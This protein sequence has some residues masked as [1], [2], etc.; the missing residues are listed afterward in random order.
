MGGG[1]GVTD[2]QTPTLPLNDY[3]G[4]KLH[5]P[6]TMRFCGHVPNNEVPGLVPEEVEDD[7]GVPGGRLVRTRLL[8]ELRDPLREGTDLSESSFLAWAQWYKTF[9]SRNL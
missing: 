8:P 2:T 9:Y 5:R 3:K 6:A 1:V 4:G 7:A